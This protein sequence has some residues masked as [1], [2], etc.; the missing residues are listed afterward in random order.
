MQLIMIFGLCLLATSKVTIQGRFA[1]EKIK[2]TYDAVLFNAQVFFFA[3]LIFGRDLLFLNG[4]IALFGAG[5]GALTV[6][7][8]M[9][10]IKAMS[11]GN[12]SLTVLIVNLSMILPVLFSAVCYQEALTLMR[13]LGL[14]L[15]VLALILN[16][17]GNN[18]SGQ[19]KKWMALSLAAA[20]SNAGISILQKI[21]SKTAWS[22]EVKPFVA[23]GYV[24]ATVL[25][26]LLCFF[27]RGKTK[28]IGRR[29]EW[30]MLLG[31]LSIGIIL[32]VF[33]VLNTKAIARIEG[34]LFFPT[35]NGG[36][37]ILSSLSGILLLKDRVNRKQLLSLMIG[38]V[39]I[40]LMNL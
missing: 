32:G 37:L 8:Q 11:Y 5:F 29:F 38:V 39:A 15:T 27:L 1:K 34:P 33:Q 23:F 19:C 31:A 28:E 40:I 17:D 20:L 7:F 36:S 4:P 12:L 9:S 2:S 25:S 14:C 22:G 35:Y 3:A 16:V 30:K 10:Y 13:I 18:R 26:L 24:V 21:F 6:L